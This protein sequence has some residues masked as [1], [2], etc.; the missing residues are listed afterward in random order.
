MNLTQ[1]IN[2]EYLT[3]GQNPIASITFG[4]HPNLNT[5]S[6]SQI[7]LTDFDVSNLPAL[8]S[9]GVAFNPT[10][11]TLNVKNGI[12]T[13]CYLM[14]CPNLHYICTDDNELTT[15]Q[16]S[17]TQL[18][19]TN[20]QVNSY[21]SFT[22]GGDFY[23]IEG[24]NRFD[25][26][27]NGC[28]SA[29]I[30]YPNLKLSLT[31]GVTSGHLFSN[32]TGNY[33]IAVSAGTHTITPILETPTYFNISPTSTS[34]T[35]P[36]EA[37][38]FTQNFCITA[39]G[40]HN[41]LETV[42]IPLTRAR[43]GFDAFYKIIYKNKGTGTQSGSVN[44]TFD[45]GVV[46]LVYANPT[47][48]SQGTNNLSWNFTNLLPFESREIFVILNV[49]TPSESPAVN[50]GDILPYTATVTGLTDET[51]TDN[52]SSLNQTVVNSFDP[53]DKTCLEGNVILPSMV[54]DYVHYMIRFENTGTTNAQ[55]IVVK[56]IIDTSKFDIS[57]LVPLTGSALYET[58]I[59]NTNEVE[60]IFENINLPFDDANNDG[61]VAFKIK[62]K[63]TLAVGDTFSNG[64][65]IYFD[66]NAPIMTNTYTTTITALGT[67]GFDLGSMFTLSPVPTK[68][69]LTITAKQDI[70]MTSVNIY[71]T[72]GQL[73]Q[74]TT[75][76]SETIDVSGLKTGSYFIKIISDKG[77]ASTTFIKE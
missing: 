46:D 25:S 37:T 54:G 6:A 36:A 16:N 13:T 56:D 41:D 23:T 44:F 74:V 71:N 75:N 59:K 34:V 1:F 53:N 63:S 49:N 32:N 5:I 29:D 18:G 64:A 67:Q 9:L 38:P 10:L 3:I 48:S 39:N 47:I 60:F 73:V 43:P 66:Y 72:I 33:S 35:F 77:T 26:N 40:T 14:G 52:I 65:N 51:P 31:N 57:T 7:P 62:T 2:L 69:S 61:Y 58:K 17:I 24:N 20:C 45:D 42:V 21:C 68:N 22:P 19:Y 28:D 30:N 12:A 8:N 11:N 76:P 4:N 70:V 15:I 55:N 27:N 50:G